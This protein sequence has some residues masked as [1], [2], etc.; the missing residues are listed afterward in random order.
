MSCSPP[1]LKNM[2][3]MRQAMISPVVLL[4]SSSKTK[5]APRAIRLSAAPG[6]MIMLRRRRPTRSTIE[7]PTI[8]ITR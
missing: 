2:K 6:I 8:I 1:A 5:I 4:P 3:T 7:R